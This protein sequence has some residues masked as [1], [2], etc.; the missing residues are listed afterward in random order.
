VFVI[1][2]KYFVEVDGIFVVDDRVGI[3]LNVEYLDT[4]KLSDKFDETSFFLQKVRAG[5]TK[6]MPR[7]PQ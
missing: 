5:I 7:R 3:H 6:E 1:G 4:L 2:I